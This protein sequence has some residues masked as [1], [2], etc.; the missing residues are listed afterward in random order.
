MSPVSAPGFRTQ[1]SQDTGSEGDSVGL[2]VIGD[3]VGL[4][5]GELILVNLTSSKMYE[6][7]GCTP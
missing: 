4:T 2:V 6:F 3:C 5:V 1:L 7:P